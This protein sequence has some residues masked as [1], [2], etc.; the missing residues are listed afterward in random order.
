MPKD[1][2]ELGKC[3]EQTKKIIK[4]MMVRTLPGKQPRGRPR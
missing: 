4:N 1:L 3:S 2:N